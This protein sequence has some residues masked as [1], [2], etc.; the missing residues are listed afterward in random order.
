MIKYHFIYEINHPILMQAVITDAKVSLGLGNKSGFELKD[1]VDAEVSKVVPG[2]F[3]LRI[4]TDLGVVAGYLVL[5][6]TNFGNSVMI[7]SQ[8]LR[9]AFQSLIADVNAAVQN[10]IVGGDWIFETL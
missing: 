5:S 10:Y 4:E 2:T 1:Y 6:K 3:V 8:V 7:S 9:T